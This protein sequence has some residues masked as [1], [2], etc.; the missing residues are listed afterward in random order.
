MS[1]PEQD[2]PLQ[3]Q[4]AEIIQFT[5]PVWTTILASPVM[6]GMIIP[7]V[8]LDLCLE[9]YHR[10]V[11]TILG[12]PLIH[13][14]EYL[15]IDRYRLGFLPFILKVACVYCGYANGLLQYAVRIAGDTEKYFCPSKHEPMPGFHEP[16]HHQDFAEFGDAKGFEHRF[17]GNPS[18]QTESEEKGDEKLH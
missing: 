1:K 4:S 9:I 6:Y 14:L 12:L 3:P 11:F 16:P 15:K 5:W 13:R 7:L 2:N 18:P 17:H 10:I 8:F